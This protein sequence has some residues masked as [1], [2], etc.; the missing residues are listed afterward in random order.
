MSRIPPNVRALVHCLVWMILNGINLRVL[1]V[2]PISSNSFVVTLVCGISMLK[3]SVLRWETLLR[4]FLY[5]E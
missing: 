1:N 3:S 4:G 5:K 2:W